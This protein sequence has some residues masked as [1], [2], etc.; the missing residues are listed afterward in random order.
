MDPPLPSF[1]RLLQ[2]EHRCLPHSRSAR[3]TAYTM[4]N[5]CLPT[6]FCEQRGGGESLVPTGSR[7]A[8][9]GCC[10]PPA[11]VIY[12]SLLASPSCRG[13]CTTKRYTPVLSRFR[14][15]HTAS[16]RPP[17]DQP[18]AALPAAAHMSVYA[19]PWVHSVHG[20]RRASDTPLCGRGTARSRCNTGTA[21]QG[22][23]CAPASERLRSSGRHILCPTYPRCRHCRRRRR[24]V[25][26]IVGMQKPTQNLF[27]PSS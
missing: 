15:Q 5:L 8:V 16:R 13:T 12:F 11:S 22:A 1:H 20:R 19:S 7:A 6:P 25:T 24:L 18:P 17:G 14:R 27:P 26:R 21:L 10:C 2:W 3:R 23:H 9:G 4:H